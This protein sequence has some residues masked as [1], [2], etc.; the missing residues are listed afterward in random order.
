MLSVHCIAH[1]L[2]VL[3]HTW[4]RTHIQPLSRTHFLKPVTAIIILALQKEWIL[5]LALG[6]RGHNRCNVIP[7]LK[8]FIRH[9]RQ[10]QQVRLHAALALHLHLCQLLPP[11]I[12]DKVNHILGGVNARSSSLLLHPRSGV[13]GVTKQ[14]K[15]KVL[16]ANNA[17]HA[18]TRVNANAQGGAHLRLG[19]RNKLESLHDGLGKTNHLLGV[20][21]RTRMQRALPVHASPVR[22]TLSIN[23][24]VM[25]AARHNTHSGNILVSHSLHLVH[26]IRVTQAVKDLK[27]VVQVLHHA[28]RMDLGR[29][30]RKALKLGKQDA[31]SVVALGHAP[32]LIP[33]LDGK[34]CLL[35]LVHD[36]CGQHVVQ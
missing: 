35:E 22:I 29:E 10:A 7:P 4:S 21:D 5:I 23:L 3:V 20:G 27:Q 28:R 30:S 6:H 31:D 26:V 17:A 14:A 16:C 34:V 36:D 12:R 25:H 19:Q 1:G 9:R 11:L 32:E 33:G 15:P 8:F 2:N 18:R 13:H 24:L